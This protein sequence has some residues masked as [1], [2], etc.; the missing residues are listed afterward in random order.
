MEVSEQASWL[1]FR[2][3][4]TEDQEMRD[5]FKVANDEAK[6]L[7][8]VGVMDGAKMLVMER[9]SLPLDQW[10]PVGEATNVTS[11]VRSHLIALARKK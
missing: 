4:K 2:Q 6:D 3:L 9:L 10:E 11:G 8:E 7:H 5:V 1:A